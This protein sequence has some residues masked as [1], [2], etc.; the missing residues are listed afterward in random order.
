MTISSSHNPI[1]EEKADVAVFFVYEDEKKKRVAQ[2]EELFNA[3]LSKWAKEEEWEAKENQTFTARPEGSIKR[4]VL[5]GLGKK[6]E[7]SAEGIRQASASGYLLAK[8]GKAR[9]IRFECASALGSKTQ[10]PEY[11]QAATEGIELA[12]YT[13]KRYQ[14]TKTQKDPQVIMHIDRA[15]KEKE[16]AAL[17]SEGQIIAKAVNKAK[18]LVNTPGQDMRPDDMV[19]V[20]KDLAKGVAEIKVKV[21]DKERLE[22]MNAGGILAVA[23]GSD[24]P[25]SLVHMQY[26]PKKKAKKKIVIVGKAVTFDSGGLS[27]KPASAMTTMKVDMAGSAAVIGLFSA[28]KDLALPIEIDGIFAACENM[29][30]GN[31]IRPGDVVETMNKKTIEIL[32]TDAEGRVTLADALVYGNKQKPDVMIDLATLTGAC[33]VALGE[34]I[35][36]VMSNDK[37]LTKELL[38]ASQKAGEKLWELPLEKSYRTLL[39]SSIADIKN[40]GGRWGGAL[41]AGLFLETFVEKTPWAHIDIAGPSYNEKPVNPYAPVGA[42][43]FGVRTLIAYLKQL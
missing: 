7:R 15:L 4:L 10:V 3:P 39:K 17:I 26:R 6:K 31:A 13:F 34:E 28:L 29:P 32:N 43:G 36:G 18:D 23:Q 27:L 37:K 38:K 22:K 41:T 11:V 21:F 30:S 9:T 33:V 19:K 35:A 24:H 14:K 5:V 25:P 2:L 42:S 20:A 12:R 1:N 16:V 40:I 8:K